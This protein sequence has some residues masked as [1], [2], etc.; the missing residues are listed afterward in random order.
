MTTVSVSEKSQASFPF[1]VTRPSWIESSDT[2]GNEGSEVEGKEQIICIM[3]PEQKY[4][5]YT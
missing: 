5:Q 1:S 3:S 2:E 4:V